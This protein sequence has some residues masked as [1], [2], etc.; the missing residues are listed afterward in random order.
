MA[1]DNNS[2]DGNI[3]ISYKRKKIVASAEKPE[4]FHLNQV[5]DVNTI[6]NGSN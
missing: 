4:K 5:S 1:Q 3:F 6:G 2:N